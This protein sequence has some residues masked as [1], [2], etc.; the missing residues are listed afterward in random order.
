MKSKVD[1]SLYLVTN[2]NNLTVEEFLQKIEEAVSNGVSIVQLREKNIGTKE[3]YEKALMVKKITDKY[4]VPLIIDDRIDIMLAVD[5]DG[6]HLGQSDISASI[7]RKII[8]ENKII[9]ISVSNVNEAIE[10]YNN[11]ADYLGVGAMFS[12][13][14][15]PEA[16]LTTMEELRKIRKTVP[17]PLVVIG[18]I[19]LETIDE[20]KFENIDGF[21]VISAIMS[22]KD[23]GK[24]SQC[25]IKKIKSFKNQ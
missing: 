12:T 17:I 4:N 2:S 20:F 9:G 8:G 5:A 10:A 18:G 7:A 22:K 23:S 15:K 14:T 16:D 3:F 11:S 6:V 25:L 13:L 19:N 1:Y 24:A 21:A